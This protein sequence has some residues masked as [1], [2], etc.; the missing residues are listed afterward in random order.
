M[1]QH[2]PAEDDLQRVIFELVDAE[3]GEMAREA[4]RDYLR[5]GGWFAHRAHELETQNNV[6][7]YNRH[8]LTTIK[9]SELCINAKLC[10]NCT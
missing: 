5:A 4:R 7:N 6:S 8:T 10:R 3:E 1:P 2:D 9:Y